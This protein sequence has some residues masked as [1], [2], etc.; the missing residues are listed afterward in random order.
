MNEGF[1]LTVIQSWLWGSQTAVK[2]GRYIGRIHFTKGEER[3]P[4]ACMS[5]LLLN[6][7]IIEWNWYISYFEGL[8]VNRVRLSAVV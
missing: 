6:G 3:L 4:G 1:S 7:W 2:K 8:L 5:I